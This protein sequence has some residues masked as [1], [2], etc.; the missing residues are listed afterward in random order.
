MPPDALRV[1]IVEDEPGLRKALVDLFGGEGHQVV[2]VG[3]GES[4]L[5]RGSQDA[6]DDGLSLSLHPIKIGL[7]H[8]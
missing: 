6:Y 1:L 8:A 7:L 5:L 4:A 3:D 2:A